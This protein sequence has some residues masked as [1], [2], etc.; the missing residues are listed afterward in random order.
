MAAKRKVTETQAQHAAV[1]KFQIEAWR[2]ALDASALQGISAGKAM[3]DLMLEARG[4]VDED[5]A[6]EALSFA[7]GQAYATTY[8]V[9]FA[10]AVKAKSVMN[11]VSDGM[12][13][14][15]AVELPASLPGNIQ[16][17][18]DACRKANREAG[19][20]PRQPKAPTVAAKDV[21]S[22]ALLKAA[23]EALR[24]E[25]EGNAVALSLVADLVDM[26][27]E[28]ADVLAAEA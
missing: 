9:P 10:E 12:A 13:I 15:K 24:Q 11:R 3:L 5:V 4:K 27:T 28:L 16:R 6:R 21:N 17:A 8:D 20:S 25:A 23:L 7:F 22:L 1:S 26:A 19:R 2:T 14:L 18:A